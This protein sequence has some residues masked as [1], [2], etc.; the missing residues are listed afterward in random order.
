[1]DYAAR[2]Y[3][4]LNGL[5]RLKITPEKL[6]ATILTQFKL[7]LREGVYSIQSSNPAASKLMTS[8][9]TEDSDFHSTLALGLITTDIKSTSPALRYLACG[10]NTAPLDA[11]DGIGFEIVVQHHLVRLGELYNNDE[12]GRVSGWVGSCN[13]SQAWPPASGVKGGLGGA[14]KRVDAFSNRKAYNT[15]VSDI[16]RL[17][18][19]KDDFYLVMRQK[20]SNA[21]GPDIMLLRK[22][23][24]KVVLDLFQC[25]HWKDIPGVDS[26]KFRAAFR[27]LGVQLDAEEIKIDPDSGS[28]G[29]S[30]LGIKEFA[31]KLS[32]KLNP[33]LNAIL[34][35][36]SFVLL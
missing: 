10:G 1:M 36:Q 23:H 13:L 27:S 9:T 15:S 30:Y 6:N 32:A 24:G 3:I 35:D 19:N 28:P 20:V 22:S 29:Y 4:A 33:F 31:D 25:K 12:N 8:L 26:K 34:K 7:L 11:Q 21:Q 17:V 2:K 5:A 14:K 16:A 18:I